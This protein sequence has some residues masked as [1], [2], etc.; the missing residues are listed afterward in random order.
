MFQWLG[1]LWNRLAGGK[2]TPQ[3]RLNLRRWLAGE[4]PGWWASNHLEESSR[5]T[6]YSYVAVRSLALQ[7]AQATVECQDPHIL[8]LLHRP[9]PN[10]S[11]ALWRFQAGQQG[12]ITGTAFVWIVKNG[13]EVPVEMYVLPTGLT[14]PQPPIA[15]FPYGSYRVEP[16]NNFAAAGG[17]PDGWEPGSPAQTLLVHGAE[18]DARDVRAVRWPHPL[19]MTEGVSAFS[20]GALTLDIA[21]QVAR[22]RFHAL[23]NYA[24]PGAVFK[25]GENTHPDEVAQLEAEV[26]DRNSSPHNAKRNL[27][28]PPGVEVELHNSATELEYLQSH[29]Q[30][31][32]DVLAL[33]QTPPVAV[34]V[35]EAGSYAAFYAA[36]MQ[37][38]ELVV[39]PNL[40]LLADELSH[41]LGVPV[42][43]HAR[44]I[45]DPDIEMR[46]NDQDIRAGAIT[47]NEYRE[48]RGLP[49]V[50]WGDAPIGVRRS[51][52]L[53][54]PGGLESDA[55]DASTTG[56]PDPTRQ[57]QPRI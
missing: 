10:Q 1:K 25:L 47:I 15:E 22:A 42:K 41:A 8:R 50:S 14:R 4:A 19:Y 7:F 27:I 57:N 6:G 30:A 9:N 16:L 48:R 12:A 31:R 32:D 11:G 21:E 46:Q 28:L 24:T 56:V 52:S 33:H 44:R 35:T 40:D 38:V 37:Y 20:A 36:M 23:R 49:P 3:R 13:M 55:P 39:Q 53:D 2:A 54:K 45:D 17:S 43:L 51:D 5:V 26:H 29:S 18:I 34:G